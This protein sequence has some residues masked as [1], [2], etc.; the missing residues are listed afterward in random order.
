MTNSVPTAL[1]ERRTN[2]ISRGVGL[3]HPV[4]AVRAQNAEIWDA[5]GKRYIDFAS[6]IAVTNCGHRHPNIM[7]AIETQL[8]AFTHTCQ[9]VT[10]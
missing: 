1:L 9:H 5:D 4:F 6:G 8:A 2:A 3:M 7:A 10:P